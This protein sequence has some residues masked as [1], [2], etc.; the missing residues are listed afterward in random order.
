LAAVVAVAQ[1][2]LAKTHKA[3]QLVVQVMVVME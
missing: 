3:A 1:D 2:K